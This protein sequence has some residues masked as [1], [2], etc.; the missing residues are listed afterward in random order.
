MLGHSSHDII[1]FGVYF[2]GLVGH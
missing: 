1:S 2:W